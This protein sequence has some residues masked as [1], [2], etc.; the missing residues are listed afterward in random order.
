MGAENYKQIFDKAMR[1]VRPKR[2][3][4]VEGCI[5]EAIRLAGFWGCDAERAAVAALLHDVTKAEGPEGQ[6]KLMKKYDIIPRTVDIAAFGPLHAITGAAVAR[7]L[8]GADPEVESA[9]RW[10]TTG[11]AGMSLFEKIIYLADYIEPTRDFEGVEQVRDLAYK[12]LDLAMFTALKNTIAEICSSSKH[13]SPETVEAY[14][15]F[16][17]L[18]KGHEK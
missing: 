14:N 1:F 13:L 8:F 16:L 3:P 9:I 7:D 4:H 6:L 2:R 11:R 15:Y 12:N 18:I 10:H 5:A 17:C